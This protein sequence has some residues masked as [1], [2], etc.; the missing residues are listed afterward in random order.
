MTIFISHSFTDKDQFDN[1]ADALEAGDVPYW[2]P[3]QIVAGA[4]LSDQLREAISRS[5]ACIFIATRNSV[6]SPW[7]NAELGAFWGAGKRVFIFVADTSLEP[8][9]LP[10]QFQGHYL[11][12][13]I[14]KLVQTCKDCMAELA[15]SISDG[16][17]VA[18]KDSA[19]QLSA[20]A[21]V[22]LIESAID[23]VT[24][25]SSALVAF[26]HLSATVGSLT[27]DG[28]AMDRIDADKRKALDQSLQQF[29][30]LSKTAVQEVAS[31]GWPYKFDLLT[32]SGRWLGFA[33]DMTEISENFLYRPCI[34]FRF[35]NNL[36]VMACA[37]ATEAGDYNLQGMKARDPIA[38]AG[39]GKFGKQKDFGYVSQEAS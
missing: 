9:M 27:Q 38:I 25:K 37:F 2:K 32:T 12:K 10:K 39:R 8:D 6:D 19:A 34:L 21:L 31:R 14:T 5:Q 33:R 22:E 23:R 30:G 11:E 28:I 13:R 17:T 35:D 7:C 18:A 36:R 26:G 3:S 4:M 1:I 15:D 29:L 16:S 24:I 20:T